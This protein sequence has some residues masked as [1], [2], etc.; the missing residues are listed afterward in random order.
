[1]G[2]EP[3]GDC[4]EQPPKT[5][6]KTARPTGVHT[7]PRDARWLYFAIRTPYCQAIAWI[8]A[9]FTSVKLLTISSATRKPA[10]S[11]SPATAIQ[12]MPAA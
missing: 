7:P 8:R 4:A 5:V 10:R 3:T 1:M 11:R 9:N 12:R 2:V 6:L